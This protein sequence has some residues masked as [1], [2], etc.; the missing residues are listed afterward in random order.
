MAKGGQSNSF[1]QTN[2]PLV[3]TCYQQVVG[4]DGNGE[5]SI[6]CVIKD[7]NNVAKNKIVEADIFP[8]YDVLK[9]FMRRK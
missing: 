3:S 4:R 5:C 6:R 7:G 1:F 8:N 9:K 2:S